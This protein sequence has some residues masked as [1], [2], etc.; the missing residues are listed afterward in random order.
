MVQ[1]IDLYSVE[2]D[3]AKSSGDFQTLEWIMESYFYH[4]SLRG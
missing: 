3:L 4:S 1:F 2:P